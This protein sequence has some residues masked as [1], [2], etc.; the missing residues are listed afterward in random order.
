MSID[1]E[2]IRENIHVKYDELYLKKILLS[3]YNQSLDISTFSIENR[4]INKVLNYFFE[5]LLYNAKSKNGKYSP[6]QIINNDIL[7]DIALKYINEHRN[8]YHNKSDITNLKDFF[9]S[10]SMVGKVTNFNPVIARKIFEYYMPFQNSTIFDYSCGYGSR[11]LGALSSKYDYNYIG[12]D[13][14]THL[15]KRLLLFSDW[16]KNTIHNN[17]DTILFNTGSETPIPS[18][19]NKIDLSFS[20]PPYFN[21]EIYTEEYSQSYIKYPTYN[22]W[23]NNYIL[24]TIINIYNYTKP[25]GLH[26]VNLQDT[27]RI[28]IIK[29]WLDIAL[30]TGFKLEEIR[31]IETLKRKSTKT[32]NK[33]LVM[34]KS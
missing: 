34:R 10:S 32:E 29:D 25:N 1:Y 31:N 7:L 8:F 13:P 3:F 15:Y 14:Y 30:A 27:K 11:M 33:L 16:I 26:I 5:D 22:E 4:N 28:K 24:P 6:S 20:S 21:Y 17:G 18:L 19:F 9:F 2:Y 23:K 12:I